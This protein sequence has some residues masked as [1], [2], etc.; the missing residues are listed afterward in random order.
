M[1]LGQ[2]DFAS[3]A[4]ADLQALIDTGVPEGILVDYKVAPYGRA[5]ADVKEF[6]KDTSSFANTSGGHLIIGI[7][8]Q[9]GVPTA[10]TPVTGIDFDKEIQRLESLMRD[11]ITP[12]I[13]GALMKAVP[14]SAGGVAIVI[15]V[16]RSWNP[17]HQVSARNT[18]RFYVR[19]SA[20]AHEVSVDELRVLFNVSATAMDRAKAFRQERLAKISGGEGPVMLDSSPGR[21]TL[22]IVP[23]SACSGHTVI[24]LPSV[25]AHTA[26]FGPIGSS[27]YSPRFNFEGFINVQGGTMCNGYT[28]IFRNGSI[29]AVRVGARHT[30]HQ[31]AF[32]P[33][34]GIESEVIKSLI[35]YL[36]GLKNI[37]VPPPLVGLL[38]IEGFRGALLGVHDRHR[39]YEED[40]PISYDVLQL[41]EFVIE[42]YGTRA[43]YEKAIRPTFDAMWN[44]GGYP[45]AR[46]FDAEGRWKPN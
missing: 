16:P 5:D 25:Q 32:L 27:H 7:A 37:G 17:P 3:I 22:H 38:T 36:G 21:V 10:L 28:Q 42:D 20:G 6:L 44:A 8:E 23:L 40:T 19:N 18:N 45:N 46:S 29:E 1:A 31:Q 39:S 2:A 26:S 41:P 35:S 15:R 24:D 43:D 13:T 14:I 4:E 33:T 12:R 9:Q 34:A 11:G 30:P